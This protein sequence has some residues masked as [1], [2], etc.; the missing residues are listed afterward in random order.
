M[1]RWSFEHRAK[2]SQQIGDKKVMS[3]HKIG[4]ALVLTEQVIGKVVLLTI[5]LFATIGFLHYATLAVI[6]VLDGATA[7]IAVSRLQRRLRHYDNVVI[8]H[9]EP[10]I[11]DVTVTSF[12]LPRHLERRLQESETTRLSTRQHLSETKENSLRI[13]EQLKQSVHTT[14]RITG[15]IMSIEEKADRLSRNLLDSS[16]AVEEITRTILELGRQIETQSSSVVQ[17]SASITEMDASIRNVAGITQRKGE[18]AK[19]LLGRTEAGKAQMAQMN[20]VIDL[21][22]SN[23]DSVTEVISV[24]DS[25]ASQTNLLSMNA[26]IEAAHAGNAGKGF[27]VVASEIR[28]LAESTARNSRL[29]AGTLKTIIDNIRTVRDFGLKNSETYERITS[30]A[31]LMSDAFREIYAATTELN[32]GSGEIVAATTLLNDITAAIKGG[33]NEIGTSSEQLRDALH[34]IVEASRHASDEI[35]SISEVS[36]ALNL[37]FLQLGEGLLRLETELHEVD[38]LQRKEKGTAAQHFALVPIMIQHLIWIIRA[39]GVIDG[40]LTIESSEIADDRTCSL[41]KWIQTDAP[42]ELK[43]HPRFLKL[44][45]D[46]QSLHGLVREIISSSG[47]YER[48]AVEEKYRN[49]LHL[50]EEIV[51]NLVFLDQSVRKVSTTVLM[52]PPL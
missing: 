34:G 50:S 3:K 17:T 1:S 31:V 10:S 13:T 46:H 38:G 32:E 33:Y 48:E 6:L 2:A 36:Q 11:S 12:D 14:T 37:V 52:K 15:S 7:T 51:T 39:R 22:H 20:S 24:I 26:A 41:G 23:V 25:I 18:A 8:S 19:A 43:N 42:V 30:E 35:E 9:I 28:K 29:V 44:D 45:A 21:V 40:R 5:L 49:L 47:K 16:S 27:A 4:L